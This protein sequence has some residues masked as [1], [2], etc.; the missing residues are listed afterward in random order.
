MIGANLAGRERIWLDGRRHEAG[1]AE[2]TAYNP[3]Q[4][5]ASDAGR[6]PWAFDSLYVEPGALER[7]LG[8]ARAGEFD[9][10]VVEGAALAEGFRRL[11]ARALDADASE[12]EAA[13]A[14]A[15]FLAALLA[16]SGARPPPGL[17]PRLPSVDAAVARLMD[18]IADP[19]P[20][21]ELAASLG[22]TPVQLVRAFR[23]AHGLPPYAWLFQRRL[24]LARRRLSA[25]EA[26]A[27]VAAD[28]GFADQAHLT[29]RFRAAFG[30]PPAAWA[31][32]ETRFKTGGRGRA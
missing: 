11:S 3:G 13:E 15:A 22:L 23:R 21:D 6:G 27:R 32:A 28:L 5:Q 1:T 29:R 30:L 8:L 18:E 14:V 17:G 31:R 25:G 12:G 26:P 10:P 7:L 19:P 2:V 16:A 9:R 24:Q 4:L 20:L